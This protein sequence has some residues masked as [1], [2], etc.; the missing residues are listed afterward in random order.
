LLH[1]VDELGF[2]LGNQGAIEAFERD[3]AR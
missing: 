1:G 3:A 2:I